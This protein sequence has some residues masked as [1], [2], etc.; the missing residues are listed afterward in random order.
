MKKIFLLIAISLLTFLLAFQPTWAFSFAVF[1]DTQNF[2]GSKSEFAK[3]VKSLQ[4]YQKIDFLVALGD[5][6][7]GKRCQKDL[8]KWKKIIAP[9]NVSIYP[10]MGNHDVVSLDF[11]N[12]LFNP[13]LNG[14]SAF[15][16]ICYSFDFE[17]S[18]FVVLSSSYPK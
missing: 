1:G 15:Q 16:G 3:S 4:K 8:Q 17:N 10:V 5:L 18:H 12:S 14:P 9:L 6:C 13:P 7:S 2:K 11:W